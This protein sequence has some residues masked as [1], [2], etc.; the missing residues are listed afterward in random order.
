[1]FFQFFKILVQWSSGF[2]VDVEN[3]FFFFIGSFSLSL[4]LQVQDLG[5]FL[6]SKVLKVLGLFIL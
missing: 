5:L 2:V 1:M 6:W 3:L 4:D